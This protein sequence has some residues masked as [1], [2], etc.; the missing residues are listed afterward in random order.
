VPT[1]WHLLTPEARPA[2]W[3]RTETGY[4]QKRVGLEITAYESVPPEV[5][6]GDERRRY[7]DTN[8]VGLGK[9]GHI[10]PPFKLPEEEKTALIE[11]LKTL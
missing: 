1:L 6:R 9:A 7:Y 11:Y 5:V 10:Y 8:L 2:V 3:T 4:D